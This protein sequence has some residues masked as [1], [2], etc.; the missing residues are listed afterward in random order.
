MHGVDVVPVSV[1]GSRERPS[2][3]PDSGT[4]DAVLTPSIIVAPGPRVDSGLDR[5]REFY[6]KPAHCLLAPAGTLPY[7]PD[8]G[9]LSYRA[10]LGFILEPT[11]RF[12]P[13]AQILSRVRGLVAAAEVVSIDRLEVGW[14]GTMWHIRYGE[15]GAFDGACPIGPSMARIGAG[16][17]LPEQLEGLR[18]TDAWGSFGIDV[19]DVASFLGYVN[20]WLRLGPEVLVL[21]GAGHGPRLRLDGQQPTVVFDEREPRVRAGGMITVEAGILGAI[22]VQIG[23]LDS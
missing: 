17:S 11:D 2:A 14:E 22:G 12:T 23:G 3:Q 13:P 16:D 9:T 18:L 4:R 20:R 5:H 6:V 15:G 19:G 1:T 21:S 8:L 10:Q 7:R